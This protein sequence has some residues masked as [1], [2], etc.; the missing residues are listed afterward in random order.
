MALTGVL[1]GACDSGGGDEDATYT[2]SFSIGEGSGAAPTSQNIKAGV[3]VTLPGQGAMT[4]PDGKT[5]AGWKTGNSTYDAGASV[6]I[7][8]DTV[9]TAQW[10][11]KTYVLFR[12]TEK[13]AV[14]IY[15]ESTYLTEIALVPAE[16]TEQVEFD[17]APSEITFYPRFQFT[18]DGLPVFTQ[19]MPVGD[20]FPKP[21]M[22]GRKNVGAHSGG[23]VQGNLVD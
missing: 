16:G 17:A 7:N 15:K 11:N 8:A 23:A 1:F 19:D 18:V 9:F 2:V 10:G 12:N 21:V 5:F 22:R 4:A 14:S 3:S 20:Q 13:F 6:A